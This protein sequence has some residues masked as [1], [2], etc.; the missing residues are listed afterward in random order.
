MVVLLFS[1]AADVILGRIAKALGEGG[2]GYATFDIADPSKNRISLR[3]DGSKV[4]GF[5]QTAEGRFPL[6]DIHAFFGYSLGVQAPATREGARRFA[7]EEW[8]STLQALYAVTRDRLWVNP[9]EAHLIFESKPLQLVEAAKAGLT[10][11]LSLVANDADA[12]EA[13]AA[14]NQDLAVKRVGHPFPQIHLPLAECFLYTRRVAAS[15]LSGAALAGAHVAPLHLQEYVQ[16]ATEARAF[17]I[18]DEV[19]AIE[20]HSQEA[21]ETRDD[22]RRYPLRHE[23]DEA[24]VD[25][26][27]W[28]CSPLELP[29]DVA[30]QLR[31]VARRL[32]M[33]YAAI[34]LIRTPA[35]RF[36][37][38]EAN[39]NGAWAF[40]EDY[41]NLPLVNLFVRL[42]RKPTNPAERIQ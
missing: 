28:K 17:V 13:F 1:S 18:G 24:V 40:A 42:L 20:I 5:V 12:I 30:S 14:E 15:E 7:H 19:R 3:V 41:G 2:V 10:T 27:R 38:L 34:D 32:H 37:F 36:V 22:W 31:T 9:L 16:K 33:A 39:A 21:A 23:G 26:D 6:S 4:S 25:R 8:F 11:P 35:G 29:P